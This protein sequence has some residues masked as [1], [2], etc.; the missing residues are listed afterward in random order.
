MQPEKMPLR[1]LIEGF[2]PVPAQS[3]LPYGAGGYAENQGD[4]LL[5]QT[6]PPE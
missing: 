4:I 5:R 3:V 2:F 1:L 6:L